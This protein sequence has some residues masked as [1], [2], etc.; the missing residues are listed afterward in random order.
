MRAPLDY[1]Q[2]RGPRKTLRG[3]RH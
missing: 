2:V 1:S 3:R